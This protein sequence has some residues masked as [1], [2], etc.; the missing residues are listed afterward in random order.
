MNFKPKLEKKGEGTKA[1]VYEP[2]TKYMATDLITFS[3][4]TCF[5]TLFNPLSFGFLFIVI[6]FL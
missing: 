6:I 5:N 2:I 3:E 1:L 4:D